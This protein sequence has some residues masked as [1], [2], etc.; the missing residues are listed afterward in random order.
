MVNDVSITTLQKGLLTEGVSLSFEDAKSLATMLVD[1][2]MNLKIGIKNEG[3]MYE[4]AS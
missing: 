4:D 2:A 1:L 3:Q